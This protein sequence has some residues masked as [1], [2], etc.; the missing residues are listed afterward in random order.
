MTPAEA[1]EYMAVVFLIFAFVMTV[2]A[3]AMMTDDD[4]GDGPPM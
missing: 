1:R 3:A 2:A 4:D